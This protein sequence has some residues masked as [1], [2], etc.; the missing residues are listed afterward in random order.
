MK[1]F[2][3]IYWQHFNGTANH[4]E[5]QLQ[6]LVIGCILLLFDCCFHLALYGRNWRMSIF[7]NLQSVPYNRPHSTEVKV[8]FKSPVTYY[9]L[10]NVIYCTLREDLTGKWRYSKGSWVENTIVVYSGSKC[11]NNVYWHTVWVGI[12]IILVFQCDK[13][14]TLQL[15]YQLVLEICILWKT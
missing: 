1:N 9:P 6:D 11:T 13:C 10:D 5:K 12:L 8:D 2:K 4:V 3:N 14:N 7:S 15:K